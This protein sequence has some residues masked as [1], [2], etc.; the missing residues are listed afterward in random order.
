MAALGDVEAMRRRGRWRMRMV[1]PLLRQLQHMRPGRALFRPAMA[2]APL[3]PGKPL[4][5]ALDS[6]MGVR[7]VC[8]MGGVGGG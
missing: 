4:K 2:S 1:Q 3:M 5:S 8:L 6:W 7:W